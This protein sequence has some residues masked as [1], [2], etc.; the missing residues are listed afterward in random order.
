MASGQSSL[1]GNNSIVVPQSGKKL[2]I[3][4]ASYNP[5]VGV[6][7]AFRFGASGPLW[8]QNTVTADSVIAKDFGDL[9]YSEG[10]I[11]ESLFLN[12]SDSVPTKWN[13]FYVEV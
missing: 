5:S 1:S 4:Y 11:D 6:T 13:V 10:A 9:R 8:L 12:L 7:A 3:Y 2:R